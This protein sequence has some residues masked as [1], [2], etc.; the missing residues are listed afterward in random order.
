MIGNLEVTTAQTT[1]ERFTSG[2]REAI[3]HCAI[4]DLVELVGIELCRSVENM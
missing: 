3:A 2:I 1:L 4:F